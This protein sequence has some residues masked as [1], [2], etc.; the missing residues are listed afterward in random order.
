M[1]TRKEW[2]DLDSGQEGDIIS[3]ISS[4]VDLSAYYKIDMDSV[5]GA[6]N[7]MLDSGMYLGTYPL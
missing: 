3:L 2:K 4:Q 7:K 5:H 1:G 6:P